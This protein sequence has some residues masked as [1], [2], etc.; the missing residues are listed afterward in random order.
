MTDTNY[1]QQFAKI[2]KDASTELNTDAASSG[3]S[4]T[5]GPPKKRKTKEANGMGVEAEDDDED[6]KPTPTKKRVKVV[7]D[8]ADA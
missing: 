4:P 2:K 1:S 5:K 8:E 7:K 3:D 6:I